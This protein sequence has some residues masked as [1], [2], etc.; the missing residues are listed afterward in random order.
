[1]FFLLVFFFFIFFSPPFPF[2][3]TF[4]WG[5]AASVLVCISSSLLFLAIDLS[6]DDFPCSFYVSFTSMARASISLV[7]CTASSLTCLLCTAVINV[8][9]PNEVYLLFSWK[10]PLQFTF[11]IPLK[12]T[13]ICLMIKSLDR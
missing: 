6:M 12:Y 11:S 1:M 7:R 3:L 13:H 2:G 9:L 8:L 10:L 4:P 5:S